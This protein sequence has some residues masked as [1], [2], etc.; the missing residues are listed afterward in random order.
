[1]KW[2][3][4]GLLMELSH[5]KCC[6]AAGCSDLQNHSTVMDLMSDLLILLSN[7]TFHDFKLCGST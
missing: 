6:C 1:M 7:S 4:V 2:Q 3:I 5:P